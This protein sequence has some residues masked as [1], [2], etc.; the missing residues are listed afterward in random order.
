MTACKVVEFV[1][2]PFSEYHSTVGRAVAVVVAAVVVAVQAM[3]LRR[4]GTEQ[5]YERLQ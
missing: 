4:S 3:Q 2:Q 1:F 5:D